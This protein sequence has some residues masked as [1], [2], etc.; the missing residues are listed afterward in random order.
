LLL[1]KMASPGLYLLHLGFILWYGGNIKNVAASI[2]TAVCYS[3]LYTVYYRNLGIRMKRGR[4]VHL[5]KK[6]RGWII[7]SQGDTPGDASS[8]DASS[9]D[10]SS[11]DASSGDAPPGD[12]S[13]GDASSG[14][15]FFYRPCRY[16]C[17]QLEDHTFLRRK[18]TTLI[19][20]IQ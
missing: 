5:V 12:G 10:A 4:F 8:G 6:N 14:Y 2:G 13:C 7:R 3:I 20:H 9:G 15:R 17:S 11:G 18:I 1:A 16:S 19:E